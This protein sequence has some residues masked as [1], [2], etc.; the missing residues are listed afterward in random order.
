MKLI[1]F[2]LFVCV[3]TAVFV[4]GT[5]LQDTEGH[6]VGHL[7]DNALCHPTV[8]LRAMFGGQC[9]CPSTGQK[10]KCKNCCKKCKSMGGC[11]G[12]R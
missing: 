11:A 3:I 2:S 8:Q 7:R 6:S 10:M 5:T 9:V 1:G 12:G 4:V